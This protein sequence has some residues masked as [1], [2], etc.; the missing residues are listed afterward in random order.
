MS[1]IRQKTCTD[2]FK[3]LNA[4]IALAIR[5][6]L[7]PLQ[8]TLVLMGRLGAIGVVAKAGQSKTR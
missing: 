2:C 4:V 6:L 5:T 8:E 1:S 7:A 3:W